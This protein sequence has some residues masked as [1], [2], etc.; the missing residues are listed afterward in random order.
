S[1]DAGV[2]LS[3]DWLKFL[4]SAFEKREDANGGI[5]LAAD[6]VSGFFVSDPHSVFEMAM[7]ATVLP[8]QSEIDGKTFLPSSRSVAF[9]KEAWRL[10]NGKPNA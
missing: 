4:V 5:D 6:V 2:K 7:G 1:T 9:K 10:R 8:N 3:P